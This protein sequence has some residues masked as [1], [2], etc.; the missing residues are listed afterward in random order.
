M[1]ALYKMQNL[2]KEKLHK[3]KTQN[4][5]LKRKI[6]YKSLPQIKIKTLC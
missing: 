5:L 4:L 3:N 1:L 2:L 6:N